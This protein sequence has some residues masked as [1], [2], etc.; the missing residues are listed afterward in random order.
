MSV[1]LIH[2]K[3]ENN[4]EEYIEFLRELIR[5]NSYNPPG[6][7]NDVALKIID[8]LKPDGIKCKV[9]PFGENRA[10][11]IAFLN[12]NFNDKNLLYN[13]H[14]DVVPPGSE[15]EWKYPPLSAIIKRKKI[16]YGRGSADMKSGVAAMVIALKILKILN[17]KLS[18]NLILNIVA[19]EETGGIFGTKWCL[20]NKLNSIKCDFSIVGEATDFK[21]LSKA[22]LLGEKGRVQLKIVTNGISCHASA[23][24]LGKNA[25]Y[26]MSDIIQNL[27]KLHD[28]VPKVS[29]PISLNKLKK[30][31]S[32]SFPNKENFERVYNEQPLLSNVMK[33]LTQFTYSVTMINAGIKENVVPGRCEAKIDFRLLP[34][35]NVDIIINEI[36]KIIQELGYHIKNTPIGGPEEIYVYLEIEQ[37]SEASYW[38]EWENSQTLKELYDIVEKV[39]NQKPFYFLLPASADA[40]FLRNTNY[41]PQTVIFG[42]GVA[43]SAHTVD[44]HVEIQDFLN[45]IKVF[46]LFAYKFLK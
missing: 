10:N 43:A 42:P 9:F 46:T 37:Q 25:I 12:D 4:K 21:P 33:A 3:I 39:Y 40:N 1:D 17:I 23:P 13:G 45:A 35:Q 20:D 34:G 31:V 16:L 5:I 27:V 22:I 36:K 19:D 2:N 7:E 28:R 44:E 32:A 38:K 15:E 14:M 26:M 6:N 11:L 29:P 8:Y 41:C 24:F 30:L 18:G